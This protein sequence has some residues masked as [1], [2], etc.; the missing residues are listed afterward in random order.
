MPCNIAIS[1]RVVQATGYLDPRD[2]ISQG[3][4]PFLKKCGI[5]PVL[6]PNIGDVEEQLETFDIKG[7]ILTGGNNLCPATYHDERTL[8]VADTS[9]DRDATEISLVEYAVNH[10]IPVLGV[11]R[12]IQLINAYF[13]GRITRLCETDSESNHVACNHEVKLI[14]PLFRT[15]FE[16][17]S[18]TVNSYHDQAVTV[19]GLAKPL[20]SFAVFEDDNLVEG[21]YHPQLPIVA[22]QWHPE[23][24][25]L[26]HEFDVQLV[27]DFLSEQTFHS[28][29]TLL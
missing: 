4:F 10:S 7:V 26:A 11:C 23:R 17:T 5:K 16:A 21:L 28:P 20:T 12:G 13:G 9:P 18:L 3:W 22:I 2:T 27:T 6:I 19:N 15:H 25:N 8:E 24:T 1:M 14:D 29:Q